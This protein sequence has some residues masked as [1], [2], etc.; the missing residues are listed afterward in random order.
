MMDFNS[1]TR[2]RLSPTP[3]INQKCR[4]LLKAGDTVYWHH[5]VPGGERAA[6]LDPRTREP[7]WAERDGR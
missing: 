2:P 3:G 4:T 1:A 6:P 5:L 7:V